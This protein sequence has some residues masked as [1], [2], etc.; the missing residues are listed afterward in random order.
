M[1]SSCE[2]YKLRHQ[3]FYK[4]AT[5]ILIVNSRKKDL[6]L[7]VGRTTVSILPT[8]RFH[9]NARPLCHVPQ[10]KERSLTLSQ[11]WQSGFEDTITATCYPRQCRKREAHERFAD[12]PRFHSGVSRTSLI[13]VRWL[14]T[15]TNWMSSVSVSI[16]NMCTHYN[17][18]PLSRLLKQAV[19]IR[20]L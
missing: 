9:Y 12:A 10:R 4:E 20:A 5:K 6:Y 18:A 8:S 1:R 3:L 11:H 19:N 2:Q 13:W 15:K 7:Y 14:L 17:W 16:N